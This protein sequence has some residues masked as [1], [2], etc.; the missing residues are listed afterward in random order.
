MSLTTLYS[1]S[2]LFRTAVSILAA[3]ALALD[4]R[5]HRL[6]LKEYAAWHIIKLKSSIAGDLWMAEDWN[7][8][9]FPALRWHTNQMNRE[10]FLT[11]DAAFS[12]VRFRS[13]LIALVS[14]L[15]PW[16]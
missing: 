12:Y 6:Y 11:T 8:T 7:R 13:R 4:N 10:Y 15:I 1:T 2:P 3:P 5:Y 16:R 9:P 14:L